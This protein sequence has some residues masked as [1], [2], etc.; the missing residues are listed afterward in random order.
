MDEGE[1]QVTDEELDPVQVAD[2]NTH[3]EVQETSENDRT[4][5]NPESIVR[6]PSTASSCTIEHQPLTP[7]LTLEQDDQPTDHFQ[8]KNLTTQDSQPTDR[9][10]SES[11]TGNDRIRSGDPPVDPNGS[12]TQDAPRY[13]RRGPRG[14][15]TEGINRLNV[16]EATRTQRAPEKFNPSAK[17]TSSRKEAHLTDVQRVD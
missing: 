3:L 1:I 8:S 12:D 7:Q 16:L 17:S 5:S 6:T 4:D 13:N 14:P 9:T 11:P 10:R 2:E 15:R